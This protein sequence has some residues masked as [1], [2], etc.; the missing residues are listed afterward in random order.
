[1][2]PAGN[3]SIQ[4]A[5]CRNLQE[6]HVQTAGQARLRK[7]RTI[8]KKIMLDLL[9]LWLQSISYGHIVFVEMVMMSTISPSVVITV[10]IL[11][12]NF[13]SFTSIVVRRTGLKLFHVMK[14]QSKHVKMVLCSCKILTYC[15]KGEKYESDC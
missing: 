4:P 7:V 15:V 10:R 1:M 13:V 3:Q 14:E 6:E 11:S 9:F 12:V 8:E 5:R 2:L